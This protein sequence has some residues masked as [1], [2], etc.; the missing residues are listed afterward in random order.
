MA[1]CNWPPNVFIACPGN[2]GSE[3]VA[4]Q[5][6]TLASLRR[7]T[8]LTLSSRAIRRWHST[9]RQRI[10][11]SD[12]FIDRS[13]RAFEH[14]GKTLGD[15]KLEKGNVR[16]IA[17]RRTGARAD[18]LIRMP[19]SKFNLCDS[20]PFFRR[21]FASFGDV[22]LNVDGHFMRTLDVDLCLQIKNRVRNRRIRAAKIKRV[23][24]GKIKRKE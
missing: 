17:F 4:F 24:N 2:N 11:A 21:C 13:V 1:S 6:P 23:C 19:D 8:Q 10:N 3:F 14:C 22:L 18:W 9:R 12:L 5:S 15:G 7:I 20:W 16:F